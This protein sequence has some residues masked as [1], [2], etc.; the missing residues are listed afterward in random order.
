MVSLI[1]A[2][3]LD[4][5]YKNNNTFLPKFGTG[6]LNHINHNVQMAC[7]KVNL[8]LKPFWVNNG[9]ESKFRSGDIMQICM[10]ERKANR[11][12]KTKQVNLELNK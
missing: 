12:D 10:F 6:E 7:A 4:N 9:N 2:F 11:T 3:L 8:V 5:L 1:L